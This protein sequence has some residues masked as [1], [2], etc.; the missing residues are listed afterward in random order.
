MN[1]SLC[2]KYFYKN[3]KSKLSFGDHVIVENDFLSSME[4]VHIYNLD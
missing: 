1:I 2:N 3:K 4:V